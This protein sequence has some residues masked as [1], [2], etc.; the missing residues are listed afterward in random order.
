MM[1]NL[2][3]LS[4]SPTTSVK[5]L[6]LVFEAYENTTFMQLA[7]KIPAVTSLTLNSSLPEENVEALRR[8]WPKLELFFLE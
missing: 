4:F 5:K 7:E 6:E 2:D 8:F 3:N 1:S